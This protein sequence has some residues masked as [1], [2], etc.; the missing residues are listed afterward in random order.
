MTEKTPAKTYLAK[1]EERVA[2]AAADLKRASTGVEEIQSQVDKLA[3]RLR[4][5]PRLPQAVHI[6]HNGLKNQLFHRKQELH[7]ARVALQAAQTDLARLTSLF[8]GDAMLAEARKRWAEKSE[9]QTQAAKESEAARD[10]LERLDKMIA[11]ESGK[12]EE[13][14]RAQRGAILAKYGFSKKPADDV[15]SAEKVLVGSAAN[16]DAFRAARPDLEAVVAA[17]DAKVAACDVETR[18]AAQAILAVKQSI[19]EAG[20]QVVLETCRA[21]VLEYH[22]SL[23]ATT[24]SFGE[25][26]ALYTQEQGPGWLEQQ[27]EKLKAQAAIG[28]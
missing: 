4:E 17:A 5:D 26:L 22:I 16:V 10:E 15:Q 20:V 12:T 27:A 28:A 1:A 3:A 14:Q 7:P 18:K 9:A 2:S 21:A 11:E 23:M 6:E 24:G 13:A 8:N 19:A 25:R